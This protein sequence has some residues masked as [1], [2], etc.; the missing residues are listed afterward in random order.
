VSR[1]RDGSGSG[2]HLVRGVGWLE[3]LMLIAVLVAAWAWAKPST[4]EVTSAVEYSAVYSF[5]YTAPP[6]PGS[7]LY[8]DDS[9]TFGDPIFFAA[10]D[11]VDVE[12]AVD[13]RT[14]GAPISEAT[15]ATRVVVSSDAGWS[16]VLLE[17]DPTPIEGVAAST[18]VPVNFALALNLARE[19][20]EASGVKGK[21]VVS[22]IASASAVIDL[23]P[24]VEGGGA[25]PIDTVAS[26]TF[27]LEEKVA[28][29]HGHGQLSPLDVVE[30][31]ET[32][33][34]LASDGAGGG[35]SLGDL[36]TQKVSTT[37]QQLRTQ[38]ETVSVGR[39]NVS[40]EHLRYGAS[41]L[42]GV[43]L[44]LLAY[45]AIVLRIAQRRGESAFLNTRYQAG[46]LTLVDVPAGVYDEA[47]V[48]GSFETLARV[49]R[50]VEADILYHA[51]DSGERYFVFDGPRVFAYEV[52]R[53][54]AANT[55]ASEQGTQGGGW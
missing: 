3:A 16:R 5:D 29:L 18:T 53:E 27:D 15:M 41:A 42:L 1:H 55:P 32:G 54:S 20:T 51:D 48:V 49:A 26:L 47:L 52:P 23:P 7:R 22:V 25:R 17:S 46:L 11:S 2:L 37:L 33:T 38:D 24:A 30:A 45:D 13:F 10:A 36:S 6:V 19:L 12:V 44:L 9:I 43:L 21:T 34:V 14:H 40:I 4:T 39:W 50:D 28:T 35:G 31:I 8:A